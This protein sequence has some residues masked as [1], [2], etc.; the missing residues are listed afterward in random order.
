[1]AP[2]FKRI[3]LNR[4]KTRI[5]KGVAAPAQLP[6]EPLPVQT[7]TSDTSI[8]HYTNWQGVQ[9]EFKIISGVVDDKGDFVR[10]RVSPTF[11]YITLKRTRIGNP[12]A[13]FEKT[14]GRNLPPARGPTG[15]RGTGTEYFR[16]GPSSSPAAASAPMM[17]LKSSKKSGRNWAHS[18]PIN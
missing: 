13:L 7:T 6:K 8:I 18:I 12:E 4:S 9:K 16:P 5:L 17:L 15:R 11:Q 3:S 10:V 14:P 2:T 1:M